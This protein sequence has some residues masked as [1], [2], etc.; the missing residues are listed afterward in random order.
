ML[1]YALKHHI[2]ILKNTA[3]CDVYSAKKLKEKSIIYFSCGSLSDTL[4]I[5]SSKFRVKQIFGSDEGRRKAGAVLYN[6]K[7]CNSVAVWD[8]KGAAKVLTLCHP[9]MGHFLL[10]S[11]RPSCLSGSC[12]LAGIPLSP[13]TISQ[14]SCR[15]TRE[16]HSMSDTDWL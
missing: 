9:F 7:C 14:L 2:I 6:R 4:C 13:S 8:F 3:S 5:R 11:R 10:L 16:Q 12:M 1:Y 15:E